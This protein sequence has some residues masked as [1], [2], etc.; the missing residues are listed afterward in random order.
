M[1]WG[2][3]LERRGIEIK[4]IDFVAGAKAVPILLGIT[5][6]TEW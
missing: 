4:T 6:V 1:E 5:G 2:S 3:P